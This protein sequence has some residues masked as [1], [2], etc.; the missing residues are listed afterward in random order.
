M[1]A[2]EI[3]FIIT[4]IISGKKKKKNEKKKKG[5]ARK[6][7]AIQYNNVK[8]TQPRPNMAAS[9]QQDMARETVMNTG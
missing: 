9:M 5:R 1:G 2:I 6:R 3:L 8:L 4:I 7:K